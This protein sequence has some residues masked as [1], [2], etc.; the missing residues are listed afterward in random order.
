MYAFIPTLYTVYVNISYNESYL[1]FLYQIV[2]Q[3][4][5][6]TESNRTDDTASSKFQNTKLPGEEMNLSYNPKRA[7]HI[8]ENRNMEISSNTIS[9]GHFPPAYIH[10]YVT[11]CRP[12][13]DIYIR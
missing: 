9:K 8:P 10:D 11:P 13:S 4:Q 1:M 3:C 6:R 12:V 2:W 7:H 5:Y